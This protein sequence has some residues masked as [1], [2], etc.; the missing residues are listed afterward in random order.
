MRPRA[1]PAWCGRVMAR[2][3][4]GWSGRPEPVR[5]RSGYLLGF[6]VVINT[7]SGISDSG[8]TL[9]GTRYVFSTP[10]GPVVGA[11]RRN[12]R[13]PS[14]SRGLTAR[15]Y[16]GDRPGELPPRPGLAWVTGGHRADVGAVDEA[17]R[18]RDRP[19]RP[20]T[21]VLAGPAHQRLPHETTAQTG[22]DTCWVFPLSS[23]PFLVFLTPG[24][25]W[26]VSATSFLRRSG[27]PWGRFGEIRG[28]GRT[29]TP[30]GGPWRTAEGED[31][32]T[33]GRLGVRSR[34]AVAA[35][36]GS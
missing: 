15:A 14:S 19:G 30:F 20:G 6:P 8:F 13:R 16:P 10:A 22:A 4:G 5:Q 27:R 3:G 11:I 21:G 1:A 9:A 28:W 29:S 2:S 33:F 23:M 7:I 17:A 35:E 34:R 18:W 24:S 36:P 25:P 31:G 26:Q 32:R 12:S